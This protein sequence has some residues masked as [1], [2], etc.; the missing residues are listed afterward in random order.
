MMKRILAVLAVSILLGFGVGMVAGTLPGIEVF[1]AA[2]VAGSI[3][4]VLWQNHRDRR[5][6]ERA[7]VPPP[8]TRRAGDDPGPN[9]RGER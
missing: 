9:R 1:A 5:E 8:P 6:L 3:A 4:V 2:A 7:L